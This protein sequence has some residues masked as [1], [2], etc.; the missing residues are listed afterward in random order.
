[1]CED[2]DDNNDDDDDNDR[3]GDDDDADDKKLLTS[4]LCT[5]ITR[6]P[7][8]TSLMTHHKKSGVDGFCS[9]SPTALDSQK[10][11]VLQYC[12]CFHLLLYFKWEVADP[13][14]NLQRLIPVAISYDL[15]LYNVLIVSIQSFTN[16]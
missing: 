8:A 9:V 11:L 1:M 14:L 16:H 7:W 15:F 5:G 4:L 3:D 10:G 6:L 12:N 13:A 2:D